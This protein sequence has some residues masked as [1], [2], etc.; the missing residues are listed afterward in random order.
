MQEDT[1]HA[2]SN[3]SDD[4]NLST[5]EAVLVALLDEDLNVRAVPVLAAQ[6]VLVPAC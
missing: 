2:R 6:Y 4:S 1:A 3:T 5:Q